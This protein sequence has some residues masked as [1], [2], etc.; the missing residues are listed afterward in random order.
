[1]FLNDASMT[2]LVFLNGFILGLSLIIALGPQNIFLIKQ[3]ARK[4]HAWLSAGICFICD[5]ILA[6]ASIT[7]LHKLLERHPNLQIWMICLGALFLFYYA[8]RAIRNALINTNRSS[9]ELPNPYTRTQIVLFALGFSLLNP[10][11]IID[12]VVIIGSGSS[13]YPDHEFIFLA[14]VMAS[15]LIWFGSLTLT[16]QHFSKLLTQSN[17]WQLMEFFSG[18]LM[19][20]IGSKLL[21]SGF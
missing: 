21:L 2:M 13:Q 6:A 11:A 5:L 14:G 1:M 10:H 4:N 17:V 8:L 19:L 15:S 12:S 3:G 16:T 18:I 20:C 9:V 7:G